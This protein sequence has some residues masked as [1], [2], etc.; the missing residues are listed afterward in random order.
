[1]NRSSESSEEGRGLVLLLEAGKI[2]IGWLKPSRII[3]HH[4]L[5]YRLGLSSPDLSLQLGCC[6]F[7]SLC[8]IDYI[9]VGN[10]P[11]GDSCCQILVGDVV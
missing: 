9:R 8:G 1:M 6:K 5:Y 7:R 2:C 4:Y 3:L 11:K 10:H